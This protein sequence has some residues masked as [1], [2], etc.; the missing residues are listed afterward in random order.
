[1]LTL[2]LLNATL[3]LRL[4]EAQRTAPTAPEKAGFCLI[5]GI[6]VKRRGTKVSMENFKVMK[7]DGAIAE[8]NLDKISGAIKKAFNATENL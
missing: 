6:T 8:F 7:R 2:F 1:M 4:C 5:P 3:E